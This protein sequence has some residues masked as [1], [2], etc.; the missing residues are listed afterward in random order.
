MTRKFWGASLL[1]SLTSLLTGPIHAEPNHGIAMYGAPALESD[2][3]HLPYVN[4]SA[5]SGGKII[6]GEGGGLDHDGQGLLIAHESSWVNANRNPDLTKEQIESGLLSAYGAEKMI[7]SPG[8]W[9]QDITDYHIDSLARFTDASRILI[10]MPQIQ[11]PDDPFH[12]AAQQTLDALKSSNLDVD[13]IY[14]PEK[15]RVNSP[16]FVASYVNYYVCNSAVIMAQ[17]GDGDTDKDAEKALKRHY[18]GREIVQL[19]AD[20]LSE[21][22]GGIHCA[23]QQMPAQ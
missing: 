18:P 23:T 5:P 9:D 14:E 13:I 10:N 2:F 17:F 11:D 21:I 15:R 4:P 22:G 7:W 16:D 20:N 3:V 8:V 1:I 6:F 19:N 12:T